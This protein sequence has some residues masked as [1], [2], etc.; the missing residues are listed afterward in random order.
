[1][2][3]R[4][5]AETNTECQSGCALRPPRGASLTNN[6]ARFAFQ[7]RNKSMSVKIASVFAPGVIWHT[8]LIDEI[9]YSNTVQRFCI[10]FISPHAV[11]WFVAQCQYRLEYL[12]LRQITGRACVS[13]SHC[14]CPQPLRWRPGTLA[15]TFVYKSC[16]CSRHVLVS[17]RIS[18]TVANEYLLL[19]LRCVDTSELVK[20]VTSLWG[21]GGDQTYNSFEGK[22]QRK[23]FPYR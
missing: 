3:A 10:L 1:M 2:S 15:P 22:P 5:A 13:M 6:S 18:V 7:G 11:A 14:R 21:V 9:K 16:K 23:I 12:L 19:S 20:F 8:A 17:V 4:G